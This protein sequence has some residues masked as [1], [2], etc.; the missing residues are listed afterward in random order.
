M[1]EKQ[2]SAHALDREVIEPDDVLVVVR[3]VAS[4]IGDAVV[5][6]CVRGQAWDAMGVDAHLHSEVLTVAIRRRVPPRAGDRLEITGVGVEVF[7][8]PLAM[9]RVADMK[10]DVGL[11]VLSAG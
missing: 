9:A 2:N 7:G 5:V 4:G 6:Q 3:G 11:V 1:R 10:E 8:F